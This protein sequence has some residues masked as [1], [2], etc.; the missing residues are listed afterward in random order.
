MLVS[1]DTLVLDGTGEGA[2]ITIGIASPGGAA[3]L[4]IIDESGETVREVSLGQMGGGRQTIPLSEHV[5][6]LEAGRYRYE[7]TVLSED[8]APVEV[9]PFY[10]MK[11][12]GVRFGPNGPQVTDGVDEY[13]I[14]DV[15][16]VISGR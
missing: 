10:R 16:E 8:G 2:P 13:S 7:V 12:E 1:G 3:V 5:S 9:Q 14:G 11:V 4:T 6:G 15:L